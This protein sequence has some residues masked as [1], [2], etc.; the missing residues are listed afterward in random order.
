MTRANAHLFDKIGEAGL[1]AVIEDFYARVF[2]DVM[3]GFLFE[4]KDRA[5]LVEREY[6]FTAQL[7]GA[8]VKYTG[9]PMRTAHAQSPIFGG[10]FERRLQI[11][12]ETLRDHGVAPE[13]AQAWIE[14]SQALRAQITKDRGSECKDTLAVAPKLA[15][16][17]T[18]PDPEARVKLGRRK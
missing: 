4:G 3:I 7:L 17:S 9:R 16:V 6:E 8:D 2:G 12:R 10:H 15:V 11:L 13:V 14:H 1:R 5:R 18:P